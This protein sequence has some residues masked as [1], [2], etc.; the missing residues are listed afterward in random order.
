MYL[1]R[2]EGHKSTEIC[3][4][5][6]KQECDREEQKCW[7]LHVLPVPNQ[8][9]LKP[10]LRTTSDDHGDQGFW[11][12]PKD[13]VPPI[14]SLSTELLMKAIEEQVIKTMKVF[15]ERVKLNA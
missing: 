2:K 8:P 6:L 11:E 12:V 13:L 10:T 9:K 3:K 15:M 5:F 1:H 4:K 7:F 14:P